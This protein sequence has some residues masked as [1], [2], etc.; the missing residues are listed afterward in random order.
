MPKKLLEE[1]EAE[2]NSMVFNLTKLCKME[3]CDWRLEDKMHY[4]RLMAMKQRRLAEQQHK[5]NQN[6]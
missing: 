3:Y 4:G 2:I 1:I 6:A 5:E